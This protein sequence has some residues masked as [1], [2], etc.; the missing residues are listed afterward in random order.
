MSEHRHLPHDH[1]VW[2][3]DPE[4]RDTD[5]VV[6]EL[7]VIDPAAARRWHDHPAVV[8]F[9][10]IGRF[11]QRSGKRIAVTIAGAVVILVGVAMLV[12]P[13]PGWVVIFAGLAILSTEYV[14][15]RR[16][17][18]KAKEKAGQAKD[19]VFRKKNGGDPPP[20]V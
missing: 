12:L 15:A 14:W 7:E 11:I 17:L 2:G 10:A 18:E 20:D 8:P 6:A 19:A 9:K 16:L 3:D 4:E 13:G 1:E 5:A